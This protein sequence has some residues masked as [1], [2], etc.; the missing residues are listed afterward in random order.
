MITLTSDKLAC[1]GG[2]PHKGSGP[3]GT[4]AV[5]TPTDH[6]SRGPCTPGKVI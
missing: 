6:Y 1:K 5:N 2:V 4:Q 3:L